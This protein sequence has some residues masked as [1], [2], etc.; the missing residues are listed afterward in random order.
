MAQLLV[1]PWGVAGFDWGTLLTV[2]LAM[3]FPSPLGERLLYLII[4]LVVG[5]RRIQLTFLPV[6][7]GAKERVKK[8]TLG[9]EA[10]AQWGESSPCMWLIWI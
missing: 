10:I 9:D 6:S 5:G 8:G 1:V 3:R 2:L 7:L 4:W